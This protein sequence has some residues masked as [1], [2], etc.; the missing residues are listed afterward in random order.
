[1]SGIVKKID[2]WILKYVPDVVKD[3]RVNLGVL[4]IEPGFHADSF[5]DL[6]FTRD[7]RRISCLDGQ[8]DIEYLQAMERD[9]RMQLQ[10]AGKREDVMRRVL[11][12]FSGLVQLSPMVPCEAE[13]PAKELGAL[14]KIYLET[15]GT[16][17]VKR[18][19]TG[20]QLIL[21]KMED[22]FVA[23]GIEKFLMRSVPV[24]S[25]TSPGDPFM[26]DFGYRPKGKKDDI[27]FLQAISFKG[28]SQ[29]AIMFATRYSAVAQA[30]RGKLNVHLHLTA[31]VDDDVDRN[32]PKVNFAMGCLEQADA[33]LVNVG[34]M[35]QVA[36][37]VALE[38][39]V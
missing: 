34:K 12:S 37:A 1:M 20:R 32:L 30:M 39:P 19:L 16:P 23:E 15:P 14:A 38:L 6:R 33:T 29:A 28:D 22:S 36:R 13:D 4:M 31:V 7:W 3:E 25:Y 17:A 27:K 11:E 21:N 18:I 10:E 2:V 9:L 26:F 8:V 35:H 24:E 5:A